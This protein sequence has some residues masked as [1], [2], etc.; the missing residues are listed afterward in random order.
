MQ[1]TE[2]GYFV[3]LSDSGC[4]AFDR[5]ADRAKA[6]R[7]AERDTWRCSG[8]PT[9]LPA[10]LNHKVARFGTCDALQPVTVA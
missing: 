3:H 5:V 2:T 9:V 7:A 1:F 8:H 6:C 4:R 10:F